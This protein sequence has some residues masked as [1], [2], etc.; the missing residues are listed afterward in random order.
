M[1]DRITLTKHYFSASCDNS[2]LDALGLMLRLLLCFPYHFSYLYLPTRYKLRSI[3]QQRGV[4]TPF[5]R[6]IIIVKSK[7][8]FTIRNVIYIGLKHE[9]KVVIEE[10]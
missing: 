5:I 1:T 10:G 4:G 9:I 2:S 8:N 6:F 3:E 7:N